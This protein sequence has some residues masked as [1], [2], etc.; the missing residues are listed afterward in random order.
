M[1]LL[2]VTVKNFKPGKTVA[3]LYLHQGTNKKPEIH[4]RI[5][6]KV[7]RKYVTDNRGTRYCQGPYLEEGLVESS[8]FGERGYLFLTKEEAKDY[9]EKHNL[10]IWISN[11]S[12]REARQYSLYQLRNVLEILKP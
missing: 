6:E 3:L 9:I 10:A 4:E 1:R 2:P 12:F 8:D 11:I 5:V 7:G